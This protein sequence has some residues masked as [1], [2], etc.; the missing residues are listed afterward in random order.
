MLDILI[1]G[2][3]ITGCFIA[4]DLSKTNLKVML[5][6]KE[7]DIAN[8]ATMANSAIIHSGHDPLDNTLKA[9]LNVRGNEM[10]EDI[11]KELGVDFIRTSAF[12]A[13][14]SKEEEKILDNLY[15]QAKDRNVPVEFLSGDEARA[16]E[17]NLS[18]AV[19]KVIELPT[20]G[21]IYPWEV[22]IALAEEALLNGVEVKLSEQVEAITKKDEGFVVKTNK[23]EYKTKIVINAAGAF[24]DKIYEMVSNNNRFKITPRRGEYYVLDKMEEPIV[25]RVIYPVPS[26][27]G[28]GVLVVPTTHGNVL[29]GPNSEVIDDANANCNTREQL[30]YVKQQVGKTVKNIPMHKIIRTFAGIRPTS[31]VHDFIIEEASD[32]SNFINVAGIESPGLASAPA[33]SEYVLQNILDKKVDLT[34]KKDYKKRTPNINLKKLSVEEKNKLIKEN[35]AFGRI[36]C[37]CEQ[38]TEGEILDAIHRPLGAT[39]VKGIKKRTRPGMGRCQGG[40]CEPLVVEILARELKIERTEVRLDSEKSVLLKSETKE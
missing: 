24:S 30:E 10:Y 34:A 29:L 6:D 14:T 25:S 17:K 35:P 9:R 31:T 13:A 33:I 27:A 16:K 21:I 2:A 19:T 4:H 15:K 26:K 32:V 12:V 7:S 40:F 28:K 11:C 22:A 36:I 39:T 18:D 8:G 5:V 38:V 20:T 3:G 23:G 1:I 37:R